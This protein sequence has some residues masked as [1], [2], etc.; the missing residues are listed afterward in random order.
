MYD[1]K[2]IRSLFPMLKNKKMQGKN[3]VFLDN[4]STTFKPQSVID[5]VVNYYSNETSNS[6][7]GDYDLCYN[8]DVKINDVRNNVA[9]FVKCN[10][11]EVVFTSG[12]TMSLNTIAYGYGLKFL[13]PGDEIILTEAE[14][15][16][17]MLPWFKVAKITGAKIVYIELDENLKITVENFKKVISKNTKI[18]SIAHIGNILGYI[19]PI[20]E[21]AAICHSF[22]AILVLDGAQ[23]V[24]HIETNFKK[25][26]VDFLT[27]SGHKMC[28]PTGIGCLIGKYELL[29]KMDSFITGGG[30]NV[31][32]DKNGH[33]EELLPPAKF[34]AGTLDLAGISGLNEA[35]NLLTS[36][37]MDEISKH[38]KELHDYAV[39]KLEN[40]PNIIIY[41]KDTD[42]GILTFNV[43]GVFPQDE[44]TLLNSKGIA[45]RSGQHCAKAFTKLCENNATV[46]MS[47]YLYTSIEDIDAFVDAL[48]NGG[49]ILDAYFA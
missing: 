24:P 43:K 18:V 40:N 14:H 32:F 29:I 9:N 23:S 8:M 5:A 48:I 26:D 11:N 47:T 36:I 31:T 37:G 28:G 42:T 22:G 44:A 4:A 7:R 39:K 21:I 15:A 49:D 34:E 27:F 3:L 10:P 35:I 25:W 19:N 16:S 2:N 1:I 12:D 6:H 45:V 17:N 46:R 38:D 20:E 30:M 33:V 13:K 41:N